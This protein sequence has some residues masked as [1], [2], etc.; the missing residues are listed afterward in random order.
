MIK[1][2]NFLIL[3]N[4]KLVLCILYIFTFFFPDFIEVFN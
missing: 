4:L 1:I 3:S 2:Y